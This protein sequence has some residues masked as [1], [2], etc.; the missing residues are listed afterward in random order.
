MGKFCENCGKE[1]KQDSTFCAE[2]G[3]PIKDNKNQDVEQP[4]E[5]KGTSIAGFVFS[6]IGVLTCGFTSLLGLILSI[7]GL[8][9]SKGKGR[10]DDE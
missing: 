7:I 3:T 5:K 1:V 6:I 9:I 10:K 2:C 4:K 8:S